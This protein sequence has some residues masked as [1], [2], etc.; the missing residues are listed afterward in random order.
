MLCKNDD[1]L[2]AVNS[3]LMCV[4]SPAAGTAVLI[5]S[6]ENGSQ[7][8]PG[9]DPAAAC[10]R[11]LRC[12]CARGG[13]EDEVKSEVDGGAAGGQ[14][15]QRLPGEC[16]VNFCLR[17]ESLSL[18]CYFIHSSMDYALIYTLF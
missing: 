2:A 6:A 15:E 10:E 7:S 16:A 9:V 1:I 14:T 17:C 18:L 12:S 8:G 3:D 4:S 5:F 11:R 13:D